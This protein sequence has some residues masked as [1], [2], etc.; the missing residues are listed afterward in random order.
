M[1]DQQLQEII[2]HAYTYSPAFAARLDGAGVKPEAVRSVDDLVAVPVLT[3]DD[4]VGL[5]QLVQ[6]QN[7]YPEKKQVQ[8]RIY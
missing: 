7:F 6:F 3:K 4:A 8:I 2:Q 1:N 5:Q